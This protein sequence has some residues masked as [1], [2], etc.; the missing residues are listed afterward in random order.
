MSPESVIDVMYEV[1][2]EQHRDLALLAD[3]AIDLATRI[4]VGLAFDEAMK[5]A[6]CLLVQRNRL[7][8]QLKILAPEIAKSVVESAKL[9][10]EHGG[11]ALH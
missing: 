11:M 9:D 1:L 5:V 7:A 10:R 4:P 8:T 3:A 6:G 2:T